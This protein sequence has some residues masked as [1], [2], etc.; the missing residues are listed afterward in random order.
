MDRI[1]LTDLRR[2]FFGPTLDESILYGVDGL[3]ANIGHDDD[4][5]RKVDRTSARKDSKDDSNHREIKTPSE[6]IKTILNKDGKRNS[7]ST[8]K[9][10][11]S[12]NTS[13]S[14]SIPSEKQRKKSTD[15][16]SKHSKS[17]ERQIKQNGE[18]RASVS[19]S[20]D[21]KSPGKVSSMEEDHQSDLQKHK[22]TG[23][24][25]EKASIASTRGGSS[26]GSIDEKRI[27]DGHNKSNILTE[28]VESFGECTEK[29]EATS[30]I[31]NKTDL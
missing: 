20:E 26:K 17:A 25:D 7:T 22:S 9:S 6:D 2:Q 1:S 8:S 5:H 31:S 12:G 29:E 23:N 15:S 21:A 16:D 3:I 19:S 11:G 4:E 13:L 14:H 24:A 30:L 10:D 27:L 18:K 28:V